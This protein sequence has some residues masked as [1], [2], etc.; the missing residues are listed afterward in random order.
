MPAGRWKER[1]SVSVKIRVERLE[2][3]RGGDE[4][5]VRF[6]VVVPPKMSREEWDRQARELGRAGSR[7]FTVDP[8]A[9]ARNE[10]E[11][12]A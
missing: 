9:A 10:V 7:V 3:E 5:R 2:R 12:G 8:G 6:V 4:A 11:G 1:Q